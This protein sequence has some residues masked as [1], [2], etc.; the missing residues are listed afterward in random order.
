MVNVVKAAADVRVQDPWAGAVLAQR[1]MDGFNRVHR[2]APWSES[3]G[4]RFKACLPF[5]FQG[6]FDDALHHPGLSGRDTQ[7]KRPPLPM[8]LRFSG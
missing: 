2:A 5:W 7:S 6:R 4:V 1:D 3:I 8:K